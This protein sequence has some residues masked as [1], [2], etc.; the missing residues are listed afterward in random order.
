MS[1]T[2][3]S[4]KDVSP[5]FILKEVREIWVKVKTTK[6]SPDEI[7]TQIHTEHSDFCRAY[8]IVVRYACHMGKFSFV[9][10]KQWF[11]GIIKSPWKS[12][13]EYLVAQA[14]YVAIMYRKLFP[15][16]TAAELKQQK[17]FVLTTLREEHESFKKYVKKYNDEIDAEDAKSTEKNMSRLAD[18]ISRADM[19]AAGTVVALSDI[20]DTDIPVLTA[21]AVLPTALSASV[22]EI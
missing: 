7:F 16:L 17:E 10:F 13:D 15:K 19:A 9:A 1:V 2:I 6:K 22:F 21:D 8:P 20:P 12:E 5:E 11:E 18:F 14:N 4:E 3:K